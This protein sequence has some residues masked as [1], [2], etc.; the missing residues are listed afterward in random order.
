MPST[1]TDPSTHS[2]PKTDAAPPRPRDLAELRLSL[3][4]KRQELL[5]FYE[6]DLRVG[7]ESTDDNADD[8]ADRANNSYNRELMFTLSDGEREMLF[9]VDEAFERLAKGE[10]GF[11][12]H[13]E[14]P[15][16]LARLKA[17]PWTRYCIACQER[18]EQGTLDD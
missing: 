4:E 11:C 18:D 13:C 1:K 12:L 3:E 14:T 9:R 17:V 15:I 5:S 10:Y 6:H 7:Q 2:E 16:S 8:F